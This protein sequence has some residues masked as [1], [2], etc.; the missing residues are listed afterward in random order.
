LAEL[1]SDFREYSLEDLELLCQRCG[2]CC[3]AYDGNPCEHLEVI[4]VTSFH[5]RIYECRFGIHYT[6]RGVKLECIPIQE[7]LQ[8]SWPGDSFCVYKQRFR[9]PDV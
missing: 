1:V 5:C 8:E 3:G 7:M 9:I 4:D 2:A 6:V